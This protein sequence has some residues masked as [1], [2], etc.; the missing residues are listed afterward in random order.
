MS[1]S[2]H[3]VATIMGTLVQQKCE[4]TFLEA[5]CNMLWTMVINMRKG[6]HS[7]ASNEVQSMNSNYGKLNEE[8]TMH[9]HDDVMEIE[10]LLESGNAPLEEGVSRHAFY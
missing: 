9:Q 7:G 1:T 2:S 8:E 10:Q 3:S 4:M 6:D 5:K